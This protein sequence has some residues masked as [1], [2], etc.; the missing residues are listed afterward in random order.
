MPPGLPG[1]PPEPGSLNGDPGELAVLPG[2]ANWPEEF[3]VAWQDWLGG[4]VPLG[5]GFPPPAYAGAAAAPAMT[6]PARQLVAKSVRIMTTFR[7]GRAPSRTLCLEYGRDGLRVRNM[8]G[9]SSAP[10]HLARSGADLSNA[11]VDKLIDGV[12][13]REDQLAG[14]LA[15]EETKHT[16]TPKPPGPA[17]ERSTAATRRRA[18]R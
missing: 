10:A 5:L 15:A 18:A 14:V 17:G 11:F 12:V 6:M 7:S 8:F 13:K 16:K 2:V 9:K 3:A 4:P 1:L